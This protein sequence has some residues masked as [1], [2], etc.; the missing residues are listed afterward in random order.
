MPLLRRSTAATTADTAPQ[1]QWSTLT[2]STYR[3]SSG[4]SATAALDAASALLSDMMAVPGDAAAPHVPFTRRSSASTTDDWAAPA[5]P[6]PRR[7]TISA[8][9]NAVASA[10]SRIA[11]GT[12]GDAAASSSPHPRRYTFSSATLEPRPPDSTATASTEEV[13]DPDIFISLRFNEARPAGNALQ[14]ALEAKGMSVF[15]CDVPPGENLA[16]AVVGALTRCK[17]AVIL[18]TK[19]YGQKTASTFSTYEE[20]QYIVDERKPFFLVKMCDAFEEEHARFNLPS[21]ISYYAWQPVI[22]TD[23]AVEDVPEDLVTQIA[24]RLH[25]VVHGVVRRRSGSW[26]AAPRTTAAAAAGPVAGPVPETG[27]ESEAGAGPG[28]Q[29]ERDLGTT[30]SEAE[31]EPGLASAEPEAA[32]EPAAEP[33][34]P[35][36]PTSELPT[37]PS[38]SPTQ[39]PAPLGASPP[40]GHGG[41]AT[42][43]QPNVPV[44][45][46]AGPQSSGE[47]SAVP[48]DL[49]AWLRSVNLEGVEPVLRELGAYD[50]HDVK[51][52]FEDGVITHED[53]VAHGMKPLSA[54]RLRRK[55]AEAR[56]H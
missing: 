9:G 26:S 42:R 21:T 34:P 11:T 41:K 5:L 3:Q 8:A 6:R 52:G 13:P 35:M 29:P 19:T 22:N 38:P 16:R 56:F 28:S 53:L 10:V 43:E 20:L 50:A 25:T 49:S 39:A 37:T 2:S 17:L 18:G 7:S 44:S 54:N 45:H 31:A 1:H 32:S 15:L 12:P 46:S 33:G 30:G 36:T 55:A 48:S 47:A 4:D 27:S 40:V 24:D 51:A 23:G 14:A